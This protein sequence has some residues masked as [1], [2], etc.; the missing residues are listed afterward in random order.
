V[1]SCIAELECHHRL[2]S[3]ADTLRVY[4]S[5]QLVYETLDAVESCW[6]AVRVAHRPV[7][8]L[9]MSEVS[10]MASA[11]LGSLLGLRRWLV[12]R[13]CWLRISAMSADVRELLELTGV[14]RLFSTD[15]QTRGSLA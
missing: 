11:A 4:L 5:G 8:D 7:V 13:G 1:H 14:Q 12:S 15:H 6:E 10:F 3:S 9:D 2:E